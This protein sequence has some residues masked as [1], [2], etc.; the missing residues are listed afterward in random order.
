[1]YI[2]KCGFCSDNVEEVPHGAASVYRKD[3]MYGHEEAQN[4]AHGRTDN[5]GS[6]EGTEGDVEYGACP[7]H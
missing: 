4:E 2:V 3:V 7:N 6:I 1:M 5:K